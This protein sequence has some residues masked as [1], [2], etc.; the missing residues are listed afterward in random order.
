MP[1]IDEFTYAATRIQVLRNQLLNE[2]DLER[3]LGAKDA[4]E[5]YRILNETDYSTHIGEIEKVEDF[6]EVID[7]GLSDTRDLLCNITPERWILNMAWY[8]YDAHNCKT[9]LKA[10]LTGKTREDVEHLIIPWGKIKPS[11]LA[12]YIFDNE[13]IQLRMKDD[14]KP[15]LERAVRRAKELYEETGELMLVDLHI[16]R[17][18]LKIRQKISI[19]IKSEFLINFFEAKT[20]LF[21]LSAFFRIKALGLGDDILKRTLTVGGSIRND[22]YQDNFKEDFDALVE[23]FR[24]T[25]Y[26]KAVEKGIEEY[27]KSKSWKALDLELTNHLIGLIQDSRFLPYGIE[28]ILMYWW[29]KEL[30]AKIIRM[31][32]IGKLNGMDQDEIR[33]NL[34]KFYNP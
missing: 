11:V 27:K 19:E 14:E 10:K 24:F 12:E 9:Y 30:N 21:N 25:P 23:I 18:F 17:A 26:D 32:M 7:A 3:M 22:K 4:K 29:Q 15:R 28:P 20:D 1:N 13:I 16:D 34:P 5:A 2:T 33:G 31:I 8:E 6:Q